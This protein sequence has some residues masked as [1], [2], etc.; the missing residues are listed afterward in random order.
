MISDRKYAFIDYKDAQ[1]AQRALKAPP[2]LIGEASIMIEARL[3]KNGAAG[4]KN[5]NKNKNKKN[6][7]ANG[8]AGAAANGGKGK[9]GT[10]S[11]DPK[12]LKG[13]ERKHGN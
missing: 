7:A 9:Q 12:E 13:E 5:Q 6:G 3:S 8:Q 10:K 1:S 11:K 2:V 4:K